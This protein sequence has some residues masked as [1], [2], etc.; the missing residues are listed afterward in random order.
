MNKNL[1]SKVTWKENVNKALF[2]KVNWENNKEQNFKIFNEFFWNL[3]IKSVHKKRV[4]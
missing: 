4:K 2:K 3:K 1:E